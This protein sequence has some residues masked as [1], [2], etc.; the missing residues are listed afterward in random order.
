MA[1]APSTLTHLLEAAGIVPATL[2]PIQEVARTLRSTERQVLELIKK[3]RLKAVK[4]SQRRWGFVL[5]PDLDA[6]LCSLNE[7][8]A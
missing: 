5:H 4:V 1:T 8:R 6:Y 7:G 2:Y 3:K